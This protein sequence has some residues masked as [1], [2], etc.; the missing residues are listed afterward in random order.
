[1]N[2]NISFLGITLYWWALI[3]GTVISTVIDILRR[4]RYGYSLARA[5]ALG[6]LLPVFCV[7][8][9]KLLGLIE[10]YGQPFSESGYSLYGAIFFVP[11]ELLI[12][13]LIVNQPY[14]KYMD[15][16]G[17]NIILGTAVMRIGCYTA[18]CCG[19]RDIIINGVVHHPPIQ[20]YECVLDLIAYVFL[21]W[22]EKTG[23]FKA[24]GEAYPKVMVIYAVIRLIMEPFRDTPKI[25][26][27]LSEAQWLSIASFIIGLAIIFILR[28]R[29]AKLATQNK[30]H[31]KA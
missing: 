9:A 2:L 29:E 6:I 21:L 20:L 28:K 16:G 22:Q 31:K 27:G 13:A 12:C 1:M 30:K 25:Y 8:G 23:R 7:I 3:L 11:V 14:G 24:S 17:L 18:G 15:F 26:A 5:I 4:K 19:P 10:N